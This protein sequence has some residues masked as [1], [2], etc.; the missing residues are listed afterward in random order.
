[1]PHPQQRNED[2]VSPRTGY[3]TSGVLRNS[4]RRGQTPWRLAAIVAI[5]V[6]SLHALG[7]EKLLTTKPDPGERFDAPLPGL[8]NGELGDFQDGHVQFRKAF[9]I[10]DGLGP[11]FNN[12][13]CASCHSGDG[14]GL[15]ENTLTR[16][17]RDAV[18]LAVDLGGPQIQDRC[19][20]GAEPERLPSGVLVSYRMPPPVFG[21]GLI[22][23]ITDSSILVHED[24]GDTDAD[25][26][27]GRANMVTP[28]PYVPA[29]EPGGGPGS[30][31][32]RF[33]RKASVSSLL[34]QTVEAYHQDI[35]MTSS[36]RPVENVNPVASHPA[37]DP[38]RDP[39]L[40]DAEIENVMQ[41][42]RMLAP[43]AP[44]LSTPSRDRG[45]ALFTSAQCVKCH[46]PTLHTGPHEIETLANRD[47]A[48]YSDLLLHDLGDVLADNRPDGSADGK[49][50]RTAPLWG[51]RIA[52]EF[53]GGQLFL[54]HDGRAH[55]V[56]QAVRYHGGEATAA[57]DAY[58]AMP[59][60]DQAALV[61][62]VESR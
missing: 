29:T 54:L 41:Y 25:G 6:L 32:G 26:I 36:Y 16:I 10:A 37:V 11:V 50:W 38:A 2:D 20:P 34:Q 35:G 33:G 51:L 59:A 57:R 14:R 49:E 60:A 30:R 31:V 23:A 18:D 21:V 1:M 5:C 62:F 13:S 45:Q 8:D 24:P 43:P 4:P 47:V 52:R 61:D 27:S 15:P 58:L 28:A 17:S 40:S 19:I 53:L 44:G 56:D 22:E 42:M 3:G 12:V 39:E 46:I 7:C 48:L 9:S 55:T